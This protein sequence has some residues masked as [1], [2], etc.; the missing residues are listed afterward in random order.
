MSN[1]LPVDI[2]FF[3]W[4]TFNVI[5]GKQVKILYEPVAVRRLDFL[6]FLLSAAREDKPLNIL[7]EKVKSKERR[8]EISTM[9]KS[10][11]K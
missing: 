4:Y 5:V 1:K 11:C 3:L 7:F 8:V 2:P 9:A 10:F 6:F